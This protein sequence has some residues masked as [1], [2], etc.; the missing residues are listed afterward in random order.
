MLITLT[1]T[2]ISPAPP[3]PTVKEGMVLFKDYR[4]EKPDVVQEAPLDFFLPRASTIGRRDDEAELTGAYL[5][6][7]YLLSAADDFM[8]GMSRRFKGFTLRKHWDMLGMSVVVPH[9][10]M[11]N[12][13]K[14]FTRMENGTDKSLV[15]VVG[16]QIIRCIKQQ[17]SDNAQTGA[18]V[19]VRGTREG[20]GGGGTRVRLGCPVGCSCACVQ[21]SSLDLLDLDSRHCFPHIQPEPDPEED[22]DE[23]DEEKEGDSEALAAAFG[24]LKS[25]IL[26]LHDGRL[27][28]LSNV[29]VRA[30]A[31]PAFTLTHTTSPTPPPLAYRPPAHTHTHTHACTVSWALTAPSTWTP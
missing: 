21:A 1:I 5:L 23:E 7:H 30:C 17:A 31:L 27:G 3:P 8:E 22:N 14:K 20:V 24:R 13:A 4:S 6:Y 19:L 28:E 18:G 11:T 29:C 12:V 10:N 15:V 26:E 9:N 16:D 25:E 2:A